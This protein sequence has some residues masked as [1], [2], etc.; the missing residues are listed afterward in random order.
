MGNWYRDQVITYLFHLS[1]ELSHLWLQNMFWSFGHFQQK[2]TTDR[3]KFIKHVLISMR[4]GKESIYHFST[5]ECHYNCWHTF[6]LLYSNLQ[7]HTPN[8]HTTYSY[9]VPEI[10]QQQ[11]RGSQRDVLCR[12]L[13]GWTVSV[14]CTN[15]LYT[16]PRWAIPNSLKFE[17]WRSEL[18][19]NTP[20]P[21]H[22]GSEPT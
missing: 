2:I 22:N 18:N 13:S 14:K 12:T 11:R 15:P 9:P 17:D 21:G 7:W 5:T 19:C 10:L 4:K 3:N 16:Q 6:M 8:T 20:L 1:F